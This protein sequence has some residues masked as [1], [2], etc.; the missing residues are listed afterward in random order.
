M[1]ALEAQLQQA[2]AEASLN[3]RE[4]AAV[5]AMAAEARDAEIAELRADKDRLREERDHKEVRP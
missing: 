3:V 1:R 5:S 2:I 4:Q